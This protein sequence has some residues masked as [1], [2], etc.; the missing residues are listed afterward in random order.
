MLLL[1]K[2]PRAQVRRALKELAEC[3]DSRL[4]HDW[5][6]TWEKRLP[7]SSRGEWERRTDRIR[8]VVEALANGGDVVSAAKGFRQR[9][10]AGRGIA[11]PLGT[12][13]SPR[14]TEVAGAGASAETRNDSQP[15]PTS[16]EPAPR[17]V[18]IR[19]SPLERASTVEGSPPVAPGLTETEIASLAATILDERVKNAV[20]RWARSSQSKFRS[21]LFCAY[22]GACCVSGCE[23]DD[24]LEAAHIEDH[25][26]NGDCTTP[27]G[28][29]LRSDLH[30]LFDAGLLRLDP[31]TYTVRLD[32]R[33]LPWYGDFEGKRI[34]LPA[35]K[36][37]WPS[38]E[39]LTAKS[40][41]G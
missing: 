18:P 12:G 29:L 1:A 8:E 24:V 34:R 32:A 28:L 19:E 17:P 6:S 10:N 37:L 33:L 3:F 38:R 23:I 7:T 20:M 11:E 35:D 13:R 15:A 5:S 2:Q 4:P 27:N 41:N 9:R 22:E 21:N 25:A 16:A 30:A 31:E 26:V 40:G 14:Q 36:R 39:K